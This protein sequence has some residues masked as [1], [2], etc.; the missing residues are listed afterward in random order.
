MLT[1]ETARTTTFEILCGQ[2][3]PTAGEVRIQGY[4]VSVHAAEARKYIGYCPQFDALLESL[5]PREHLYLYG[6][7]KGLYGDR[8]SAAVR[9]Q[10]TAMDLDSYTQSRAGQLSGGNKRKSEKGTNGVGTSGIT[11]QKH[12]F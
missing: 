10:L 6:R 11:E 3:E 2:V 12:A 8:V 1:S 9:S 7:L 4:D 5:T